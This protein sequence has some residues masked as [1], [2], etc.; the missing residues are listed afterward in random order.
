MPFPNHLY[1]FRRPNIDIAMDEYSSS[2]PIRETAGRIIRRSIFTFLQKYQ[3][4]TSTAALLAF[5]FAA[6][7]LLSQAFLPSSV[8]LALIQRRFRSLFLAAGF[9]PSSELFAI[10]NLKLSQTIV[11]YFLVLPFSLSFLLLAKAY[12]IKSLSNR[13]PAGETPFSSWITQY[14]SLFQ[15]QICSS[16]VILSVN[17]TCFSLLLFAINCFD[18]L[19]ISSPEALLFVSSVGAVVY[20]IILANAYIICNMAL[21]LSGME[22][23]GGYLAILKACVLIQGR[24]S[25]AMS[26][27]VVINIALA[28]IEALFQYR[29][30][31]AYRRAASPN[32]SMALEG[33]FIGY[34]YGILLVI[35]TIVGCTFFKSCRTFKSGQEDWNSVQIPIE[36][37]SLNTLKE[38]P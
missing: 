37:A 1:E 29:I 27:A 21:V 33:L 5:P 15:T 11:T 35:D 30:V 32:S 2:I 20:S 6:S 25:T 22:N 36:D 12:I 23:R 3:Y 16:L 8:V 31:K 4:F 19:G 38:V 18:V 9:P 14:K 17:A 24:S 10:L 26:L 7:T 13:K 34:L 28:A